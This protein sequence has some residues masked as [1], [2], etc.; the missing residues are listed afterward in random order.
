LKNL[1]GDVHHAIAVKPNKE[2]SI[3]THVLSCFCHLSKV[4][5]KGKLR[6]SVYTC[7]VII[8]HMH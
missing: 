8:V 5:L 7:Y 1:L 4:T 3:H 6:D 2:T